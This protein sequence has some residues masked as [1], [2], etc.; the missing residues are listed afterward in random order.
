MVRIPELQRPPIGNAVQRAPTWRWPVRFENWFPNDQHSQVLFRLL[1]QELLDCG[2][3]PQT[4]WSRWRY[5]QDQTR[6]LHI[7]VKR[8]LKLAKVC[9]GERDK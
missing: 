5:K 8:R 9:A 6:N 7:V 3:P 1:G 2:G 4:G